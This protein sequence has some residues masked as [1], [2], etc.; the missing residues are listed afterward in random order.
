LILILNAASDLLGLIGVLM[1]AVTFLKSQQARDARD[2][3]EDDTAAGS[4]GVRRALRRA[5]GNFRRHI[6]E[7]AA[8]EY[9]Y[10]V[11]MATG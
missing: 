9:S 1:L 7:N 6:S 11:W 2:L 10:G 3:V 8:I 5:A 4:P